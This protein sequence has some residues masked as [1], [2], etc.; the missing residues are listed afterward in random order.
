M[1]LN[2]VKQYFEMSVPDNSS[3]NFIGR[4]DRRFMQGQS[5]DVVALQHEGGRPA[6]CIASLF[7]PILCPEL[8]GHP[9]SIFAD[10]PVVGKLSRN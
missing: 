9:C 4:H 7:N 1:V 3:A 10:T 2:R 8:D 5:S 6:R